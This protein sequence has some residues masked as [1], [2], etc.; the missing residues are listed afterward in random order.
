M[1]REK[2]IVSMIMDL[3]ARQMTVAWVIPARII[4]TPTIS[5]F[6]KTRIKVGIKSQSLFVNIMTQSLLIT[7]IIVGLT[8]VG[9]AI[10]FVRDCA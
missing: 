7:S 1:D 5:I 2:T 8:Y 3:T 6:R 4:F 9:I 10:G